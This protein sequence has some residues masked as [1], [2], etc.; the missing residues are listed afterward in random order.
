MQGY[1][2]VRSSAR[3]AIEASNCQPVLIEDFPSQSASSRNACLDAVESCDALLLILG[4]RSGYVAQSGKL[5]VEEELDAALRLG[6]DV[7]VLLEE[8]DQRDDSAQRLSE[9]V[10]D[11][12][13]GYYRQTFENTTDLAE[14]VT[15]TLIQFRSKKESG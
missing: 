14:K 6:I 11:Y 2:H 12:V 9:Q 1:E 8:V 10:S 5:V 7:F 4:A 13:T 3:S 15:A